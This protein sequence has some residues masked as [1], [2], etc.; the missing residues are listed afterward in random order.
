MATGPKI[1]RRDLKEDKVYLTLAGVIDIVVRYRLLIA[2]AALAL[3]TAFAGGYYLHARSLRT[4][5]DASWALYQTAFMDPSAERTAALE[6]VV[7]EY[8]GTQAA[9]FASFDL[10]NVLYDEGKYE[11]ALEAFRK[12]LRENPGHLLAPSAAEAVGYCQESLGRWKEAIQTYEG[13][14][15]GSPES[16]SVARMS[17]RLGHCY[18]KLEDKEKAIEA[19]EK[20]IELAPKSLWADYSGQRLASLSPETYAAQETEPPFPGITRPF[21]PVPPPAANSR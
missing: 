3:V 5:A 19:Y 6:K 15:Q 16:L 13:V 9:R 8:A 18:E 17:Y 4:A 21:A 1:T 20:V 2:L 10:A 7:A 12:F 11:D 14:M